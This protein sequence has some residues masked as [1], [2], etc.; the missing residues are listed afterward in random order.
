MRR[1]I[2]VAIALGAVLVA[3]GSAAG[4]ATATGDDDPETPITGQALD[5]ATAA[6]LK[7]TGGGTV[8][9]TEIGDEESYYEVEVSLDNG[10]E[11][12]VQ[13]NRGFSVVGS[14]TETGN[15]DDG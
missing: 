4:V 10:D 8:T 14:E 2:K 5:R 13:L 6:A 1:S 7:Y 9:Q 11:V 3:T 12:D 15:Q